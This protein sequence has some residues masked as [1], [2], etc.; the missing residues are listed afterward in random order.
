MSGRIKA[1]FFF[2]QT[3]K[4]IGTAE[5]GAERGNINQHNT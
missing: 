3:H 1:A 4:K 5:L 2:A